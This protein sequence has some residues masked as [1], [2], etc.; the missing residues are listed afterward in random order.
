MRKTTWLLLLALFSCYVSLSPAT[1]KGR[2]Y[3]YDNV[4]AGMRLLESFNAWVKGRPVPPII[5]TNHGPVPLLLDLPFIKAGKL[6][7]SPDFV[8][9]LQPVLLTAALLTILFLWLNRFCTPGMSLLLTLTGAFSTLLWPYA[10]IGLETKQSFFLLLSG[11]L[12]L[13]R[14]R[15]RGWPGLLSF[16]VVC[17]LGLSS[18]TVGIV[19]GPAI[20]YLIY[21]QFR[22]D[23]RPRWRQVLVVTLVIVGIWTVETLGWSLYWGPKGGGAFQLRAW[24]IGSPLQF[25]TNLIGLFGSPTKGL[26]VFAPVLL[27][28]IYAIPRALRVQRQTAIFVLLVTACTS[29]FMSLLVVTADELWGQRFMH[30]TIC[31]LLLLIGIAFPRFEWRRHTALLALAAVGLVISFLGAF[32]Y[33]G[34]RDWAAEKSGHNTLEWF[35]GDN[36]WNEVLFDARLFR[37]W[38]DGGTD[39]VP[40]TPV[41]IWVWESPPNAAAWKTINLR[42]FATPQAYLLSS[43]SDGLEGGG[44]AIFRTL[45]LSAVVGPLLLA[46]VIVRIAKAGRSY[47]FTQCVLPRNTR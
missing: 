19:L 34:Q 21:V 22:D 9:S 12:G 5:W 30:V 1:T 7:I 2:G 35:A 24:S 29:A 20:A 4:V 39:A 15:I 8:L 23:W 25:F 28:T 47:G 38:W 16:A 14:G 32:F 46:W 33:Y 43:R 6:F 40:W 45:E 17:A 18:K 44:V 26:F 13:S 37:V 42:D 3:S 36:V 10:Y 27:F 11:Y 41:H 31:P